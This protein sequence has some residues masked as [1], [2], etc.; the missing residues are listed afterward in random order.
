MKPAGWH[1]EIPVQ[2]RHN[3]AFP[4]PPNGIRGFSED[5]SDASLHWGGRDFH[6]MALW[7]EHAGWQLSSP[8][9]P[10][11]PANYR[12]AYRQ[13]WNCLTARQQCHNHSPACL[14]G[15]LS[16]SSSHKR[17]C[18]QATDLLPSSYAPLSVSDQ[19]K[20]ENHCRTKYYEDRKAR[21]PDC[22]ELA[23]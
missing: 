11:S 1:H 12:W 3:C 14:W 23:G 16:N 8:S 5:K 4:A 22:Q 20:E 19:W 6:P 7:G 21:Y 2:T 15:C 10:P 13:N 9:I 18:W 17:H